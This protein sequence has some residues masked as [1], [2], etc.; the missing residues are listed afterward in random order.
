MVGLKELI[1]VTILVAAEGSFRL[2]K[3]TSRTELKTALSRIG[4]LVPE[5]ILA[6]EVRWAGPSRLGCTSPGWAACGPD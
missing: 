4:S 3:I 1:V 5:D 2:P 6:V